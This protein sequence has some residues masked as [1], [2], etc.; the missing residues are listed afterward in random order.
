MKRNLQ[1]TFGFIMTLL[2]SGCSE[3]YLDIENKNAF[4]VDSYYTTKDHAMQAIVASYDAIKGNGLYGLKYPFISI[5]FGDLAVMEGSVYNEF[6]FGADDYNYVQ[7][8]YGYLFRG[9]AKSNLALEKIP[10][11][12]DPSFDEVLRERLLG[13]ARFL[14]ALYNFILH[15]SFYEPPLITEVLVDINEVAGN[16][17][18][19]EFLEQI[20]R[21]LLGY[22]NES[23]QFIPGAIEILP[24]TYDSENVGRATKGAALFLLAKAYMYHEKWELAKQYLQEIRDLG[25][26]ELSQPQ[27]SDSADYVNAYLCNFS[28]VDLS[29]KGTVYKAEYNKE[30]VFEIP[31]ANTD[32]VFTY[33]LPGWMCDG[34]LYSTYNAV[35][36]WR[37]VSPEADFAEC[38]EET[39]DHVAGIQFDPRRYA[40]VYSEGDTI[41]FDPESSYYKPFN[42]LVH[43]V[44]RTGYGIRKYLYPLHEGGPAPFNAP[45]NWRLFRYADVLLMHAEAE[46]HVD[47]STVLALDLLNQVRARAGLNPLTEV[48][49]TAIVNERT[50]EF[51]LEGQRYFDLVRWGRIGGEWPKP[52]DHIEYF[53]EGKTEFLPIPQIEISRC[54]GELKQNPGW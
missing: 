19:P 30:S 34:S 45:H 35:N 48:T 36:G 28:S 9:V 22:E 13:E 17:T 40:T 47:G 54:Q 39:P 43:T 11:I 32:F 12:E 38:F 41:S 46:F 50:W 3:D 15:I 44:V 18:W 2:V 14:R 1:Y 33:Y 20:E 23:G 31:F 5:V 4:T 16:S 49:P 7:F 24:E 10:K 27:G 37:N 42:P 26:Y 6:I 29:H 52:V 25:V 51:G 53:V 21:D 8:I